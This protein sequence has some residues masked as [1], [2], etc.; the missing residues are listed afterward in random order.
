MLTWPI[1]QTM[2]ASA[3]QPTIRDSH[4]RW[5]RWLAHIRSLV[6]SATAASAPRPLDASTPKPW[7]KCLIAVK[8]VITLSVISVAAYVLIGCWMFPDWWYEWFWQA[9]FKDPD[10]NLQALQILLDDYFWLV[11]TVIVAI[12]FAG[13]LGKVFRRSL[14]RVVDAFGG[15]IVFIVAL[16]LVTVS[17]FLY[18]AYHGRGS[19]VADEMAKI[20]EQTTQQLDNLNILYVV[21]I[22]TPIDFDYIDRER[23][24]ALYNQLEPELV[25]KER[26]ISDN[27]AS[28][29]KL[30]VGG[31]G[32]TA[33]VQQGKSSTSTSSFSRPHF[34]QE[35]ECIEVMKYLVDSRN[36]KGYTT[37]ESWMVLREAANTIVESQGKQLT[38]ILE[39]Q[40][41]EL[42]LAPLP[43]PKNS[44]PPLT[45]KQ[46]EQQNQKNLITELQTLQ[47]LIFLDN[48]FDKI[49]SATEPTLVDK[50]ATK[51]RAVTFRV[52]IPKSGKADLPK[53][54]RLRV[55]GDVVRPLAD[56]GYVDVR[57]I[58]IF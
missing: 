14:F 57:A 56:D 39:R 19:S 31:S 34:S 35:R 44:N 27:A 10:Y 4:K 28:Q 51:P 37:S 47:G 16:S 38:E 53:N 48:A 5:Q 9:G 49:T 50:F 6:S 29:T 3:P 26:T 17:L 32:V 55:F 13:L 41:A 22:R 8:R 2:A 46:K 58:A 40:R 11:L 15:F 25:E 30:G 20:S 43:P 54:G 24:D 23:V 12:F 42:G 21:G 18:H 33:E 7:Q 45:D 36:A 52:H 1:G